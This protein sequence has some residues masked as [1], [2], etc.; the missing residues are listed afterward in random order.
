M[1]TIISAI[2]LAALLLSC[3]MVLTES[4]KRHRKAL[5][6]IHTRFVPLNCRVEPVD[7]YATDIR[8]GRF[9][10]RCDI[11]LDNL[12]R[13]DGKSVISR[14][15]ARLY[16]KKGCFYIEPIYT[17]WSLKKV[18]RP[19]VWVGGEEAL[20]RK[21]LRVRYGDTIIFNRANAADPNIGGY[22][23]TIV[24][25]REDFSWWTM[26]DGEEVVTRTTPSGG[27]EKKNHTSGWST[28]FADSMRRSFRKPRFNGRQIA[29]VVVVALI[30]VVG[31]FLGSIKM[32]EAEHALGERKEDTATVLVCG[33]D[34]EG[35]RTDTIILAYISGSEKRIDLL[36]IPRDTL[37][38]DDNG[39]TIKLNSVYGRHV[40]EGKDAGAEALMDAVK[41]CIGY[42]PDGYMVVNWDLVKEI[43]DL[44]GGVEV[45]L[46]HHITVHTDGVE[47]HVPVGQHR[48]NGEQ[49]LATL[50][51]RYGYQ[52]ADLGRVDVQRDV[53]KACIRQW[54]VLGNVG[55]V[56]DVLDLVDEQSVTSLST[57]NMLWLAKT[58]LGCMDQISGTTLEGY[59]EN[60]N[61]SYYILDVRS[62]LAQLNERFNP[63]EVE[64][65]QEML[66]ISN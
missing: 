15:H 20:P 33:V 64:I 52:N 12:I 66:S 39:N 23:F 45:D 44:M 16:L 57:G 32:P 34:R 11:S 30:L 49:M 13:P 62:V 60:R 55:K 29:A 18:S 38:K 7:L 61:E 14:I 36:S 58:A 41:D 2:G 6:Q 54:L 3:W 21:P 56:D 27:S 28:G 25:S 1:N 19:R 53:L 31:I 8:I 35:E 51:Y 65:T 50:R 17:R 46:K 48:L 10:R 63:Y 59:V 24:D 4:R 40:S 9:K 26:P 47:V 22:K 37:V 42:R 5:E 43:T